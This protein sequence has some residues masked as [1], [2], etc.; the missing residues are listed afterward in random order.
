MLITR[1]RN[2]QELA[3][4]SFS[5]SARVFD[6]D[7][8]IEGHW[9]KLHTLTLGPF[10]YQSDFTIGPP[11][12]TAESGLGAFLGRHANLKYIRFIWSFKR[13]MSPETIPM[14]LSSSSLPVLDTV[15]GV[16]QQVAELPNPKTIQSLDLTSEPVYETRL[17]TVCPIL[18]SLTNL[19]SL[20]IWTHIVD[21][22]RDHTHFFQSILS[23]CPKLTDFHFMCTTSFTVVCYIFLFCLVNMLTSRLLET[24]QTTHHTTSSPPPSQTVLTDKRT[25][26]SRRKYAF[27]RSQNSQ[28]QPVLKTDQCSLGSRAVSQSSQTGRSI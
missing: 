28:T 23:S 1:C 3:I 25:Q 14:H 26:I 7:R 15:I 22:T 10:G 24:A 8:V 6:F 4:C 27:N 5:S 19:T 12:L 16:Y 18:Q 11:S 20:D 13:W 21:S 17:A 9:L 2:L